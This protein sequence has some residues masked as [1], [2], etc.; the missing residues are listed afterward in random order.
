MKISHRWLS[1]HVDL[2]GIDPKQILADLTMSTAEIEELIR[3]GDGLEPLV[4][5]HVLEAQGASSAAR[6]EDIGVWTAGQQ[7]E[8]F[9]CLPPLLPVGRSV[10]QS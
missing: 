5:G 7:R 1:R 10:P 6:V 4:V 2:N 3:F 9:R 8:V